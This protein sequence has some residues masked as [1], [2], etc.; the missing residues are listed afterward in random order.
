MRLKSQSVQ[1]DITAE[2]RAKR[3]AVEAEALKFID[4]ARLPKWE[5]Q[6]V[7]EHSGGLPAQHMHHCG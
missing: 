7:R 2:G 4:D 6:A 3:A 1:I 5:A